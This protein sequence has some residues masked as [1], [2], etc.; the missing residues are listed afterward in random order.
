MNRFDRV[1]SLLLLLQTRSVVTAHF[2]AEHFGVSERTVYRDIRTLE[3]AG[4]P[5]GAEA[6]VGYF[7]EQGYRL[8]PIAF[9][10]D[11]AAALLLGEKLLSASLDADS[12]QDFGQALN[13]VRAVIERTDKD[14]LSAFDADIEVLPTGSHFPVDR[15]DPYRPAKAPTEA[16]G[17][18]GAGRSDTGAEAAL[19]E[20]EPTLA[21]DRWLRECRAALAHRQVVGIEYAS[22]GDDRPTE[23]QVEPIGLFYYHWHWHLIAWCRLRGAYRDFRLDR[24]LPPDSDV[25]IGIRPHD[26]APPEAPNAATHDG[27]RLS[28]KVHLTE[29]LGDVTILDVDVGGHIVKSVLPEDLAARYAPGQPIDLSF[30]LADA[31]YFMTETGVRID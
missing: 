12:L 16:G 14:R 31:H 27:P 30:R 24:G 6:G 20:R 23:R 5:I 21:G 13:K 25:T 10:L 19:D 1:T 3:N 15:L 4:V 28:G 11:E 7:L 17:P 2:L 26:I 22:A 18:P 8:P 29:P 9:T